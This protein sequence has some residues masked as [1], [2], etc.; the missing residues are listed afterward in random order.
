MRGLNALQLVHQRVVL[1]VGDLR[2]VQHVIQVLVAAQFRAQ[3]S[4]RFAQDSGL[5]ISLRSPMG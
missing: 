1:G 5:G 2:R 4:A 3:F